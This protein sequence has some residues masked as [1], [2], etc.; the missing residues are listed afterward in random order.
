MFLLT[1]PGEKINIELPYISHPSSSQEISDQFMPF[2][3]F[4]LASFLGKVDNIA[5]KGREAQVMR[6]QIPLILSLAT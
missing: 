6:S 4:L 3:F 1:V 5:P 2:M